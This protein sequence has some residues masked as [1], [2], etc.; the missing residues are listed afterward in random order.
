MNATG[1]P[2]PSVCC[3]RRRLRRHR[4]RHRAGPGS[5][6]IPRRGGSRAGKLVVSPV[7]G[8]WWRQNR[9]SK[10]DL[11]RDAP[12]VENGDI[13]VEVFVENHPDQPYEHAGVMWF[14]DED[15]YVTLNKEFFRDK[16]G[17]M[18]VV[19]RNGAPDPPSGEVAYDREGI[20]L[21]LR[22]SG[23]RLTGQY[24]ASDKDEWQEAGSHELPGSGPARIGLHAGY[25]TRKD[26]EAPHP[27]SFSR[28]RILQITKP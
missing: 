9:T 21:R 1:S 26:K 20:W 7:G 16:E 2:R 5:T 4:L 12:K 11:V 22:L 24:R 10:N 25:G 17:L 18:F 15:N 6:K 8:S 14:Y 19:E 3:S 23:T 27:A 13:A 28:F